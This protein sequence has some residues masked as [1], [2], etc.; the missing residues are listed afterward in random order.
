MR[1][2][3]TASELVEL[4]GACGAFAASNRFQDSMGLPLEP[5]HEIDKIKLSLR[6][7]PAKLKAYIGNLIADWPDALPQP[8]GAALPARPVAHPTGNASRNSAHP[9]IPLIVSDSADGETARFF[10]GAA[11]LCGGVSNATRMWAHVPYIAKAFLP[12]QIVMEREGAGCRLPTT[13]KT[14]ILLRTAHRN[15]AAYSIAHRGVLARAAG[16]GDDQLAALA[17]DDCPGSP[18]F[19]EAEQAALR[20]T[21]EVQTNMAK[22]RGD[23]FDGLRRH[24][25][26]AGTV[27]ITGL[28]AMANHI[29]LT[30]NA[31]RVP[32]E[33]D[34]EIERLNSPLRIDPARVK[35]YV[36]TLY[37][38]WP[39]AFPAA[40]VKP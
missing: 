17:A 1:E 29:D 26:D 2:H 20:W 25:D 30:L 16:L 35:H 11:E 13:L 36:E 34:A 19:T 38:G 8:P 31:L 22:R 4:T 40:P 10:R 9:L 23:L 39:D 18:H 21:D 12:Y 15:R 5:Q 32:L 6:S 3:Y 33:S 37:A 28:C 7:D 27:E 24:F 14:M